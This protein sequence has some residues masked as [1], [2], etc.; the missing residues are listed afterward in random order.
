VTGSAKFATSQGSFS[1]GSAL[2]LR[3]ATAAWRTNRHAAVAVRNYF[4]S[5]ARSRS[6]STGPMTASASGS[7]I[8]SWP[9]A[10]ECTVT[11]AA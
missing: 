11:P 6:A 3:K 7:V 9:A 1:V 4:R 5:Q 10:T 8:A 2:Y